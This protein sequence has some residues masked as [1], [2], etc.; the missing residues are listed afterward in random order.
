[1]QIFESTYKDLYGEFN[2]TLTF[3][4]VT[5]HMCDNVKRHGSLVG[6]HL[7]SLE[8]TQGIILS[9]L[10]GTRGFSSQ[11]IKCMLF[12]LNLVPKVK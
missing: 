9:A 7:Y 3:H 12:N 11:M 1:M 8:G 2:C 4:L 5:K 10:N 6:H